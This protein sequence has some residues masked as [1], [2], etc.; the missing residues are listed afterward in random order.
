MGFN[1]DRP[2]L[3]A[4]SKAV[5]PA[6][7]HQFRR[8]AA[9][10]HNA[11]DD[12]KLK[13]VMVTSTVPGEGKTLTA[14]NLAVILSESYRSSVLLID[15]DLRSPSIHRALGLAER[16]GLSD[17]LKASAEHRLPVVQLSERLTLL[18]AGRQ[19]TDPTS[20]L[21]SE[22]MHHILDEARTRFDW[23]ILDT[24][25]LTSVADASLLVP[26]A[27]AV[28]LVVRTGAAPSAMV[29]KGIEAIRD[30]IFGVV[31][32]GVEARASLEAGY[33]YS[34]GRERSKGN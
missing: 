26:R 11:Q 6:L 22:R 7:S 13:V 15:A 17:G 21:A 4:V 3:V 1:V 28:L 20:G 12:A 27:D 16:R 14:M 30:R 24:P 33:P 5:D 31:L 32:N 18:P 23:V 9:A 19:D 34:Y 8:V 25:P 29:R 2:D 10:L